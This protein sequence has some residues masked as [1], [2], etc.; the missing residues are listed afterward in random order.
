ME[1]FEGKTNTTGWRFIDGF[2][3]YKD[4]ST[5]LKIKQNDAYTSEILHHLDQ[6]TRFSYTIISDGKEKTV[7]DRYQVKFVRIVQKNKRLHTLFC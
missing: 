1:S 4:L 5:P 6:Q 2:L 3:V 7:D